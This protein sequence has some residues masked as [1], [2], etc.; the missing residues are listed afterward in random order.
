ML[1]SV[2]RK[3]R[4]DEQAQERQSNGMDWNPGSQYLRWSVCRCDRFFLDFSGFHLLVKFNY[5]STLIFQS[6]DIDAV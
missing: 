1:N 2:V 5:F 3:V 6:S 4:W